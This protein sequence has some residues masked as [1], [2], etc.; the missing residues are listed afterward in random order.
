MERLLPVTNYMQLNYGDCIV[1]HR[2]KDGEQYYRVLGTNRIPEALEVFVE[3]VQKEI[4]EERKATIILGVYEDPL[5]TR[6]VR[7]ISIRAFE[8]S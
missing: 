2:T 1:I 8:R 7:E 4:L 5:A 3:F 6:V